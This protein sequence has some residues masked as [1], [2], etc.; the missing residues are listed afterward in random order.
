MGSELNNTI[1]VEYNDITCGNGVDNLWI[2]F[3]GLR[4]QI[5]RDGHDAEPTV[6]LDVWHADDEDMAEPIQ[7]ITIDAPRSIDE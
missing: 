6:C 1:N 7:T 2:T 5:S 3:G 4:I